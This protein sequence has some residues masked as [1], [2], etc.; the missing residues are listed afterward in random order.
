MFKKY[1][2]PEGITSYALPFV[3][4]HLNDIGKVKEVIVFFDGENF[5]FTD[6]TPETRG[7]NMI[8]HG[9]SGDEIHL[10]GVNCGYR[11]EGPRGSK[12]ILQY[13][14]VPKEDCEII[15]DSRGVTVT[16]TENGEYSACFENGYVKY[17]AFKHAEE[18][19]EFK[20]S[21]IDALGRKIFLVNPQLKQMGEFLD[22]ID[23][24]E[25]LKIKYYFG[26]N[27]PFENYYK[28][29]YPEQYHEDIDYE[30]TSVNLI[31]ETKKYQILCIVTQ[32]HLISLLDILLLNYTSKMFSSPILYG[33]MAMLELGMKIPFHELKPGVK[34][35]VQYFWRYLKVFRKNSSKELIGEVSLSN[36]GEQVI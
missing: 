8:I 30:A 6:Y 26:E 17:N 4:K 31:V 32:R 3:K 12:S 24:G 34:Q 36:E 5:I 23:Y 16:F 35:Y 29:E 14:G 15:S 9:W 28:H 20:Y 25:I 7:I 18:R 11:G 10:G 2:Q 21:N 27:S 1:V 22:L 33:D 13:L 19:F